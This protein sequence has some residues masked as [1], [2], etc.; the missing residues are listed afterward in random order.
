MPPVEFEPTTSEGEWPQTYAL[1]RV[2]IGTGSENTYGT[3]TFYGTSF[4]N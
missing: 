3:R 4:I 1:D 2:G